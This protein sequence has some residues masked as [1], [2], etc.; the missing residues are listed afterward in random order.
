M[1]TTSR[2]AALAPL[3]L[4]CVVI[5]ARVATADS[6]NL[7][8]PGGAAAHVIL[9]DHSQG[10]WRSD[11]EATAMVGQ[12]C[13]AASDRD[14]DRRRAAAG[15]VTWRIGGLTWQWNDGAEPAI[16]YVIC[17]DRGPR[18]F[19]FGGGLQWAAA[20]S[21]A[22]RPNAAPG[23]A[24]SFRA[25]AGVPRPPGY[26]PAPPEVTPETPWTSTEPPMSWPAGPPLHLPLD[27]SLDLP[28]PIASI[29]FPAST[30]SSIVNT[31]DNPAA[32]AAALDP[33]IVLDTPD[34]V[35]TPEPGTLWLMGAGLAAWRIARRKRED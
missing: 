21:W 18:D 2:S 26:A 30:T 19:G 6:I 16:V 31:A 20:L 25:I 23:R 13:V 8:R 11:D 3:A 4:A 28:V 29:G 15:Y 9:I 32:V 12:D 33:P 1:V 7:L 17:V 27:N 22:S 24:E 10:P 34:M 5:G 14:R 35:P